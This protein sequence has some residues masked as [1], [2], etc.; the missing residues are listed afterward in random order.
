ALDLMELHR[1]DDA[2]GID[3]LLAAHARE[4]IDNIE[5]AVTIQFPHWRR[6]IEAA[7]NG[8]RQGLFSLSIPALLLLVD[9]ITHELWQAPFFCA[10]ESDRRLRERLHQLGEVHALD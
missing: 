5:L 2:E 8:H 7:F 6:V 3:T 9:G 4:D 1:S 10:N